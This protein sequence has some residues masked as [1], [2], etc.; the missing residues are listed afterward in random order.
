V[1]RDKRPG[2]GKVRPLVGVEDQVLKAA[3]SAG[4]R[5][6]GYETY[7]VQDLVLPVRAIRYR[8]KRWVTPHGQ[9]VVAPLPEGSRGHFVV[10]G[11]KPRGRRRPRSNGCLKLRYSARGLRQAGRCRALM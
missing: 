11:A 4:L 1:L 3:A 6:K 7:L 5:F 9:T 2:R 8:R 10:K